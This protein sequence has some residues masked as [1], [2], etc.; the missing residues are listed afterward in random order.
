MNKIITVL[1]L[2]INLINGFF[3]NKNNDVTLLNKEISDEYILCDIEYENDKFVIESDKYN[4]NINNLDLYAVYEGDFFRYIAGDVIGC[5]KSSEIIC[6]SIN[7]ICGENIIN[8]QYYDKKQNKVYN[9]NSYITD[10]VFE[11]IKS[12]SKKIQSSDSEVMNRIIYSQQQYK[13]FYDNKKSVV[14]K[15]NG[16]NLDMVIAPGTYDYYTNSDGIINEYKED[17]LCEDL[18]GAASYENRIIEIVPR[19]LFTQMGSFL[20]VGKEYG[21]YINTGYDNLVIMD[22]CSDVFVFDIE[23]QSQMGNNTRGEFEIVP[24]FQARYATRYRSNNTLFDSFYITD[25]DNIVVLHPYWEASNYYLSDIEVNLLLQNANQ[26]NMGDSGYSVQNDSGAYFIGFDVIGT[27]VEYYDPYAITDI[28]LKEAGYLILEYAI[29]TIEFLHIGDIVSGGILVH[30]LLEIFNSNFSFKGT[31]RNGYVQK[32]AYYIQPNLQL[33]NY[34]NYV[35]AIRAKSSTNDA[36]GLAL[37]RDGD[38]QYNLN[39]IQDSRFN[40]TYG[41]DEAVSNAGTSSRIYGNVNLSIYGPDFYPSSDAQIREPRKRNSFSTLYLYEEFSCNPNNINL[42]VPKTIN[43]ISNG[44]EFTKYVATSNEKICFETSG[45][46]DTKMYLY[47]QNLN[48]IAYDDDS[49]DGNNAKIEYD[50]VNGRIYYIKT[51]LFYSS[52]SGTFNLTAS[53]IYEIISVNSPKTFYLDFGQEKIYKFI[54]STTKTYTFTVT[55]GGDSDPEMYIYN[56]N[57][58]QLAYNDDSDY[59]VFPKISINLTANTI[60]YVKV[61]M[62]SDFYCGNVTLKVT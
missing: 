21:F 17:Y 1:F 55:G 58:N 61:N 15:S 31:V 40:I 35:K 56:V 16:S 51:N 19:E 46:C 36:L 45:N 23:H 33:E 47:D 38:T 27:P 41:I 49:G 12:N 25:S 50:L 57:F 62:I 22:Y 59:D 10:K 42:N 44:F 39:G 6:F 37:F 2:S 5:N 48:L 9:L 24:L 13:A 14:K 4:L 60:Y 29:G 26:L 18:I 7:K 32:V 3:F 54:P 11:S 28:Q 52:S 8:V 30:D 34:G 20:Y 53:K 43:I